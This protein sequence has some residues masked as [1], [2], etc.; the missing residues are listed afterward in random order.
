MDNRGA[1][2][3]ARQTIDS[4]IFYWKPDKWFKI[5]FFI[6]NKVNHTDNKLF[7]RGE[8]LTTYKEIQ[9]ATKATKDQVDKF[10][11]WAKEESMLTTRKTTR[12]M[13]ISVL[14]YD[15]YQDL[16]HYRDDTESETKAKQ[17]RNRSDTITNNDKN[18]KNDNNKEINKEKP[19]SSKLWL[20]TSEAKD[21]ISSKFPRLSEQ[22]I[23]KEIQNAILWL[24]ENGTTKKDYRAF[25][26]RWILRNEDKLSKSASSYRKSF[27][28]GTEYNKEASR[29][30]LEGLRDKFEIKSL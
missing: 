10:I 12:G 21:Y 2:I 6:V 14:N 11:R 1:T 22:I 29:K 5:W 20:E 30:E 4:D 25:I 23:V 18:V 17:K 28:S 9:N 7:K 24:E 15:K 27:D 13:I 16:N 3:W 8:N 19:F 26:N